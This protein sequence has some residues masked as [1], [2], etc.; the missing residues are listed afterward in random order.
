VRTLVAVIRFVGRE[1]WRLVV[2]LIGF[3]VVAVG[4]VLLVTPGPG[5]LVIVAGLAILSTQFAWAAALL[6][7]ARAKAIQAKD[8]AARKAA[9]RRERANMSHRRGM[10]PKSPPEAL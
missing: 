3:L 6:D 4:L 7:Y 9:A 10:Q 1:L 2:A 8:A 5:L